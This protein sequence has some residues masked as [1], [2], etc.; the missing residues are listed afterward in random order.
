MPP[1]D[2]WAQAS[3]KNTRGPDIMENEQKMASVETNETPRNINRG[4]ND[5]WEA[6]MREL[7]DQAE[8]NAK[9]RHEALLAQVDEVASGMGDIR[10]A[11]GRVEAKMIG[12][13]PVTPLQKF[14]KGAKEVAEVLAPYVTITLFVTAT[15]GA[16]KKGY[17]AAKGWWQ[18][19]Q[20][21]KYGNNVTVMPVE[22]S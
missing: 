17:D 12:T 8:R 5:A 19:R 10:L 16:A 14:H 7:R 9:E 4:G 6:R 22:E 1:F 15:G 21:A 2:D 18:R 20:T 11:V 3:N 13:P